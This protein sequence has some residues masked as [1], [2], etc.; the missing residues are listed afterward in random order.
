[1]NVAPELAEAVA[2]GLGMRELPAPMPKVLDSE[3]TPEVTQSP[4]LSLF[5]RPGDGSIAARRVAILVA[6]GVRRRG[7]ASRW[8]RAAHGQGAVPRFV[9]PT[10]GGVD[11]RGGEPIEVDV[12]I[13]AAPSVLFDARG[14]ARRRGRG[15]AA[16]RRTA[17]CWSS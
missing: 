11:A 10:L 3:V 7:A 12:G 6:D 1:M 17:G 8:P 15:P 4:A 13:E 5:A 16:C 9:G 2:A 14:P